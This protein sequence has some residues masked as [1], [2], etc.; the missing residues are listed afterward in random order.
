MKEGKEQNKAI[1]KSYENNKM[2]IYAYT[3]PE[4]KIHEGHVKIGQT[5][6]EKAIERIY[7][8]LRGKKINFDV[9][10][11]NPPYQGD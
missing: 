8:Q 1:I 6:R 10:I 9:I 5:S 2:K 3:L 4:Y 11:G 7:E